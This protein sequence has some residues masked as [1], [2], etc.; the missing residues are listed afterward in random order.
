MEVCDLVYNEY[1]G[2]FVVKLEFLVDIVF[3]SFAKIRVVM[4]VF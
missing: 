4:V 1:L 3:K 2:S